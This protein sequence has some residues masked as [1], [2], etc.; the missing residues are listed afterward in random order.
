M[1]TY[2]NVKEGVAANLGKTD[3][4]IY[5]AKREGS[6]NRARR[7]YYQEKEWGFCKKVGQTLTFTNQLAS[8][9][10]DYSRKFKKFTLYKYVGNVPYEYDRVEWDELSA[11]NSLAWVY[12]IDPANKQVKISTT[13]AT[14]LCDYTAQPTDKTATD[15]SQDAD[16]ELAPDTTAIELLGT[17]YYFLSARQSKGGYKAF[18]EEYDQQLLLDK[19][20]DHMLDTPVFFR[21]QTPVLNTGYRG[22]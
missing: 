21:D 20:A 7:K 1:S 3:A 19:A 13:D 8:F 16:I 18:K 6:I 15:G 4:T 22:R 2:L 9:P 17:A 5:N 12:A 11:Y 10:S 14:L